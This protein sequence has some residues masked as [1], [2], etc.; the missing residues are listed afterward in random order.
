MV[1]L[2]TLTAAPPE[3]ITIAGDLDS[4]SSS[5]P[6][7]KA[8]TAYSVVRARS[9]AALKFANPNRPVAA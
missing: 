5:N 4:A 8:A 7:K 9:A 1:L 2:E 6:L 3:P